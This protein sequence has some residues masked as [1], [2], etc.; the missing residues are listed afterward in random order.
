M[1]SNVLWMVICIKLI[2]AFCRNC[3]YLY[4]NTNS[5]SLLKTGSYAITVCNF[6]PTEDKIN[7]EN[8]SV[9]RYSSARRSSST[10]TAITNSGI[11]IC[12]YVMYWRIRFGR[13]FFILRYS[14][15]PLAHAICI[16]VTLTHCR[17]VAIMRRPNEMEIL[18][19]P[20]P[21]NE[22][23]VDGARV[24]LCHLS[25]HHHHQKQ[26]AVPMNYVH[27]RPPRRF[28]ASW[29]QCWLMKFT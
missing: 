1:G 21:E 11:Y 22:D 9:V 5:H 3:V 28:I 6:A 26:L 15:A 24:F 12:I 27:Q 8:G 19:L 20:H 18:C 29:V 17:T 13:F 2:T 7:M 23:V 4:L 25:H 10:K 14:A 16:E